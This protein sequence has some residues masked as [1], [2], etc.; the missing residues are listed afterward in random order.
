MLWMKQF[1]DGL[2]HWARL[3]QWHPQLA[4][5]RRGEDMAHRYLQRQGFI[6]VARNWRPRRGAAELD[7]IAR[8]GDTLVFLEVKTRIEEEF[9]APERAIDWEKKRRIAY[10]A[11]EY[12]RRAGCN[13]SQVRFDV[14]SVVPGSADPI[15]HLR[16]A[17]RAAVRTE[18]SAQAL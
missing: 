1:G 6:V 11:R 8:D 4:T 18:G 2:R 13:W 12:M 17:F 3:R 10:A 14:I 7:L 9:G 15:R 5:G 16:D